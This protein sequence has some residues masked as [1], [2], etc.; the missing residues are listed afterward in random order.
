MWAERLSD[1]KDP[2]D[3][4]YC[5]CHVY[6][7]GYSQP[8]RTHIS[9]ERLLNGT[10]ETDCSAGVSWWLYKGGFLP[11]CPWFSTANEREYLQAQGF[12]IIDANAG[13]VRMQRNDVLLR[14][15]NDAAGI[16]G[17]TALYIGDGMQA[18]ALRTERHD[19]GYDGSIPGDQ[20]GGETVVRPLTYDWDY[21]IRKPGSSDEPD[22]PSSLLELTTM[23]FL[24]TTSGKHRGHVYYYDGGRIWHVRTS[25]QQRA[26]KKAYKFA[27][28]HDMPFFYMGDDGDQLFDLVCSK[29]CRE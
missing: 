11:E 3:W 28:G 4:G 27:T 21:V 7:C 15:R 5:T 6:S 10:A 17:H 26:V 8:H 13:F 23:T 14:E 1:C 24:F 2:S 25:E 29:P 19:A 9:V 22:Q 12:E 18:E 20:D 16:L